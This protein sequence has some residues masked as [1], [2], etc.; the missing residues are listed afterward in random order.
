[1]LQ[2]LRS[3]VAA[4][5]AVPRPV[6][7]LSG[8]YD[9]F[10]ESPTMDA[11][12][13]PAHRWNEQWEYSEAPG[14][15]VMFDANGKCLYV[16]TAWKL[17]NRLGR[18]FKYEGGRCAIKPDCKVAQWDNKPRYV[19]TVGVPAEVWFEAAALEQYLIEKLKPCYNVRKR[20][21]ENDEE[22]IPV[23]AA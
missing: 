19:A 11:R 10:P 23:S 20:L 18:Y 7:S 14:V 9:L 6:P 8:L 16:G 5:G 15:Y 21:T 1:M 22:Q 13:M 2:K 3:E 12:L 4:Y 17:G